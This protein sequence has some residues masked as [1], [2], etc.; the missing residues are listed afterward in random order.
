MTT[1][2]IIRSTY[3]REDQQIMLIPT[4][5]II[6]AIWLQTCEDGTQILDVA[7]G[8]L[9]PVEDFYPIN[10]FDDN[11]DKKLVVTVEDYHLLFDRHLTEDDVKDDEDWIKLEDWFGTVTYVKDIT[12][13]FKSWNTTKIA[14]VSFGIKEETYA[15]DG[16][17]GTYET[18]GE[19]E[20]VDRVREHDQDYPRQECTNL[21]YLDNGKVLRE[22]LPFCEDDGPAY[23]EYVND[24]E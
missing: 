14:T 11:S 6:E 4:E 1:Y 13:E 7:T 9:S 17:L 23:Y 3:D 18:V 8:S 20:I 21:L 10:Y 12:D 2:T 22:T 19:V 15:I 5:D 16:D 24:K